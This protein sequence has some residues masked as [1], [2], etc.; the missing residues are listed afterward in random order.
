MS[1]TP[2]FKD[3]MKQKFGVDPDLL[4]EKPTMTDIAKQMGVPVGKYKGLSSLV[5]VDDEDV[6]QR[7]A[8]ALASDQRPEVTDKI[9]NECT[10]E[11]GECSMCSRLCCPFSDPFHFHH[12]GCPSCSQYEENK[13]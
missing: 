12:D 1:L 5:W 13:G 11:G 2:A 6:H 4:P 9:L 7:L 8:V 10:A 3:F